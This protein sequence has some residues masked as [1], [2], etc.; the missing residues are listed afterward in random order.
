MYI[1]STMYIDCITGQSWDKPLSIFEDKKMQYLVNIGKSVAYRLSP[2]L[3]IKIPVP[4]E[5]DSE[6]H[7]YSP[8]ISTAQVIKVNT[9]TDEY[10]YF[11]TELGQTDH[12]EPHSTDPTSILHYI[13]NNDSNN[14]QN[15]NN[16][17]QNQKLRKK[18]FN[19]IYANAHSPTSKYDDAKDVSFSTEHEYTFE[20]YQHMIDFDDFHIQLPFKKYPLSSV[21]NHQPLNVMAG[22]YSGED[23]RYLWNFE[24]WHEIIYPHSE[25]NNVLFTSSIHKGEIP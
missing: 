22:F 20:F 15:G 10:Q 17:V 23:L 25:D 18:I 1:V 4:G 5:K 3:T 21:L 7:L 9:N 6:T 19:S 16:S 2:Q 12:E 11:S 14:H 24:I 8:L 13:L